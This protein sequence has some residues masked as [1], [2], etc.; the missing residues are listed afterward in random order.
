MKEK[1]EKLNLSKDWKTY[2]E[3]DSKVT[4]RMLGLLLVCYILTVYTQ[5]N[6]K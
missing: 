2:W 3:S 5:Q 4:V 1:R 6:C